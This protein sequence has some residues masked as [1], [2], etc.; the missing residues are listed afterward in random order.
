MNDCIRFSSGLSSGRRGITLLAA[1]ALVLLAGLVTPQLAW[2]Q[3]GY[4]YA[5]NGYYGYSGN[6]YYGVPV[7]LAYPPPV[8]VYY[9]GAPFYQGAGPPYYS[10]MG[11]PYYSGYGPPYVAGGFGVGY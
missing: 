6:Y 11:P 9:P 2:A 8:T 3:W 10:G 4:G 7:Y 5:Q 1:V